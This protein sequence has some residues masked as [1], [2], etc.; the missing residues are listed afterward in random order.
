MVIDVAPCHL[1]HP[2]VDDP[3]MPPHHEHFV[4][5][6]ENHDDGRLGQ[7]EDVLLE[8][9][10]VRELDVGDAEPRLTS[11]GTRSSWMIHFAEMSPVW[12]VVPPTILRAIRQAE[13]HDAR[14]RLVLLSPHVGLV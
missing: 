12:A 4:V 6:V 11:V 10:A 13:R 1:P 3:T 5:V 8:A 7:T 14:W 2:A 9:N